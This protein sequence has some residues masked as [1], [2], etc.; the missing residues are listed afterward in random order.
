MGSSPAVAAR[1][2]RAT[3]LGVRCRPSWLAHLAK[4][5]EQDRAASVSDFLDRA[6]EHYARSKGLPTPPPR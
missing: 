3:S 4:L 5:A 1:P 6:V 2:K